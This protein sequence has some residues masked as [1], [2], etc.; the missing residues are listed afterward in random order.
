MESNPTAGDLTSA[1]ARDKPGLIRNSAWGEMYEESLIS[2]QYLGE[3]LAMTL[4]RQ[5]FSRYP[6]SLAIR[7]LRAS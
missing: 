4:L 1:E 7:S 3:A 5:I 2:A 6:D